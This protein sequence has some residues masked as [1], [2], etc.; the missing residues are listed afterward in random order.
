MDDFCVSEEHKCAKKAICIY[1]GPGEYSCE[2]SSM[3]VK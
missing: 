1:R 2:V 3:D